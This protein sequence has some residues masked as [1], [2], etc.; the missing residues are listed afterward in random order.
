MPAHLDRPTPRRS[1]FHGLSL[2]RLGSGAAAHPWRTLAAW[3]VLALLVA[4][5]A[6]TKGGTPQD[7]YNVPGARSQVGIDQLRAHLPGAGNTAA[8]VVV[9]DRTGGRPS[10]AALTEL[11]TRL[12]SMPH[13]VQVFPAQRSADGDTAVVNVSYDA[14]VTD[15]D[16][17]GKLDPLEQAVAPLKAGGLQVEL[18]GELPESAA[19]PMEGRG[20]LIGIVAAL[21]ILVFAFGS[22]VSAGLPIGTALVGLGVGSAGITL[23]AA[24]TDVSTAAPMVATMVGLGVGIDYALLLVTR[25]AEYLAQGFSVTESAG[26]AA[27]TAGRSVVFAASTV[28]VSLMGLRLAGL[29]V[30]SSFGFA[31]GIAV[32]SVMAASLTLVP[33]LC[34]FAGRRLLPRAVRRDPAGTAAAAGSKAARVPLTARWAAKVAKR[35]LLWAMSAAIVMLTLAVP[36]LDMRTWPQDPSSQSTQVTTRRAYDLVSAEYGAGSN[37]PLTVVV[38]RS[39][40]DDAAVA[41]LTRTLEAR[42]D[43]VD[44]TPAVTSPDSAITVFDAIPAFGPTDERTPALVRDLRADLPAGAELTGGTAF[45]ADIAEMLAG[46]LWIVIAFV[47]AVSVLLLAMV[48]RSV[49]IPVK[50]AVMN[51]LSIGAAYGVLTAVFQWGWA[52]DLLGLDHPLA[53]SSWVPILMFAILFG[54]S[55]DYEVFLLSRIREDW[56]RTG[57]SHGSVVRGLSATGRVISSAAAIMVAVFLGFASEVDVVVKQLGV[58]MAVA[59][60]LDATVVRMVLVPAT[61][62]LLGD[63]NWWVPRWLDRVLPHVRAEVEDDAP[64]AVSTPSEDEDLWE[65]ELDTVETH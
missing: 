25:H 31:T 15:P 38:D 14:P 32:L 39:R 65:R 34:R 44:V 37:G 54:L 19:A 24:A 16:L 60:L 23:L 43:I 8:R 51:L 22:V 48:F 26:R 64:A 49:V 47:V 10:D 55:M 58:G 4:G 5:L 21:V 17:M 13:V 45:F 30:Y 27:A 36:A 7:D 61:M 20:E 46:R 35:P 52:T 12:Q 1:R 9:H 40:L 2:Y 3:A 56:A 29:P 63:W 42:T 18:G 62:S 57:D 6:A 53:V 28:L 50:A 33:V 59:I 41:A 11:A